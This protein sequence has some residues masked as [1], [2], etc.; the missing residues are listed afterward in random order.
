MMQ[1]MDRSKTAT[2]QDIKKIKTETLQY[3]D[4]VSIRDVKT[5][6]DMPVIKLEDSKIDGTYR[7]I[8]KE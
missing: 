4:K 3:F 6:P 1:D 7:F 2:R 5:V 8:F